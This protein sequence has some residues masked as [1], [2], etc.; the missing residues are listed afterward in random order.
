MSDKDLPSTM[1]AEEQASSVSAIQHL[2]DATFD[3]A[4]ATCPGLI[5]VDF[6]ADWCGPCKALNP[7]LEALARD[8]G[9]RVMV[10]KVNADT[11]PRLCQA[12]GIRSLPTVLLLAPKPTGPGATVIDHRVGV[13]PLSDFQGMIR[14]ATRPKQ[15]LFKTVS[16]LFGGKD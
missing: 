12:F 8:S 14:K 2:S 15:S 5:L 10:A 16:R 7:I 4:L 9:D 6:W 1:M 13:R 11:N 3:E